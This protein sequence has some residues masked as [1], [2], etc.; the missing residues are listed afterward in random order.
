[1][2]MGRKPTSSTE[3]REAL[4]R[5]GLAR[6]QDRAEY[7]YRRARDLT[8]SGEDPWIAELYWKEA[9]EA[10]DKVRQA[11]RALEALVF[12]AMIKEG[13]KP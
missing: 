10:Q 3:D 9:R 11:E 7:T 8:R 5:I 6:C 4:I 13:R 2:Y 12:T 1:M